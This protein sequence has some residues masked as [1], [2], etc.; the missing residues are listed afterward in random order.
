MDLTRCRAFRSAH[1]QM[2][3]QLENPPRPPQRSNHHSGRTRPEDNNEG[4]VPWEDVPALVL[5]GRQHACAKVALGEHAWTTVKV[6]P[7]C[8]CQFS[9]QTARNRKDPSQGNLQHVESSKLHLDGSFHRVQV[10]VPCASKGPA[11]Q[12]F[13]ASNGI[14]RGAFGVRPHKRPTC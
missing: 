8:Q 12:P 4:P 13:I 5:S 1:G 14:N 3:S 2:P 7:E 10:P 11:N 9:P 6:I